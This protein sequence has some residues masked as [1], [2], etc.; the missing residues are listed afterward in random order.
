MAQEMVK[1]G[2]KVKID[3][4]MLTDHG[5]INF[6]GNL[7]KDEVEFI[8]QFGLLTL[9]RQGASVK[10]VAVQIEGKDVPSSPNTIN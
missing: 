7:D 10:S 4:D 5:N 6:K 9:L 3:F 8:L 2:D 1:D